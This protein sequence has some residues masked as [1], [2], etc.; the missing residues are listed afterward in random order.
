M[1][2]LLVAALFVGGP[3]AQAAT[4][5]GAGAS[6]SP[7]VL[8]PGGA[9]TCTSTQPQVTINTFGNGD[10][11]A[12]RFSVD[13]DW[14]DGSPSQ[15]ITKNGGPAGP[16]YLAQHTY[17]TLK[18]Y[19][20]VETGSVQSGPCTFSP[21]TLSFT[22]TS[23]AC[24]PDYCVPGPPG[25]PHWT[26]QAVQGLTPGVEPLNVIVSGQ[27]TVPFA[28]F[29][30]ALSKSANW[31]DAYVSAEKADVT[32]DGYIAQGASLRLGGLL[33]GNA[34]SL[35]GRE[36]HARVWSQP[37]S[38]AWFFAASYETACVN[39][40]GGLVPVQALRARPTS[41]PW[42]CINGSTHGSLG[43]NGYDNGAHDLA[44]DLVG[45]AHQAGWYAA[46]RTV[47]GAAGIGEG[48][49]RFSGTVYVVTI[50]YKT[51]TQP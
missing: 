3:A 26:T 47:T 33:Q 40:A 44:Y 18:T 43:T 25:Q 28:A 9:T 32:G 37:K 17:K 51:P 20:I 34:L 21:A 31:S 42:H 48:S 46:V 2:A 4:G 12:C 41:A 16:M 50:D 27:S 49:A 14:G 24:N 8:T 35:T 5:T 45:A 23:G 39:T 15:K 11:S 6:N 22:L 30:A 10:S 19:R 13:V 1:S 38:G 29:L 36:N 7:C